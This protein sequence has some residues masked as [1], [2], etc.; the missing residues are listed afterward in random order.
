MMPVL[1]TVWFL[2]ALLV[3]VPTL[4]SAIPGKSWVLRVCDFPRAQVLWVGVLLMAGAGAMFLSDAVDRES[5]LG[6]AAQ[7]VAVFVLICLM[8][9]LWWA[10]RL[11]P[12]TRPEVALSQSK[13]DAY[14]QSHPHIPG[15][16]ALRFLTANVDY[17]NTD[18]E[19]ALDALTSWRPHVLAL[20]ETD[21]KW[22]DLIDRLQEESYPWVVRELRELGRGMTLLSRFPIESSEVRYLVD[23]DRPSIWAEICPP[24]GG[25]IRTVVMHPP[26]PGLPRRRGS[27]RLDSTKRDIEIDVAASIIGDRP[28]NHWILAGD[29]NDVGWSATTL[30]A[31][32]T[33]GLVDPRVGRGMYSTYPA[34]TPLLRY[35][36]DHVLV[37]PSFKLLGLRRLEPIGSDHLPLL[38]DFEIPMVEASKQLD[39][40]HLVYN[41][42]SGETVATVTKGPR[43]PVAS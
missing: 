32:K 31:K 30:R 24:Q 42:C 23:K 22:G 13:A 1:I 9:Q 21:D 35:P 37:S 14:H 8:V 34:S 29:F 7:V 6:V 4:F 17:T 26:P 15:E 3:L 27:G 11:T 28:N 20:V 33:S 12:M 41:P 38:A 39:E 40:D 2:C 16:G 18:R 19:Q 25:C 36:I 43:R 5:P 10:L